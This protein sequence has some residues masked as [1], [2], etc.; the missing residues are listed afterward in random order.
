MPWASGTG[1]P[2]GASPSPVDR[3]H[4]RE[5]LRKTLLGLLAVYLLP[6]LLLTVYF[7]IQTL[8]SRE[9]SHR[10]QLKSVAEY[11][12]H[13]LDLFIRERAVNLA[14]MVDLP[15]AEPT[16]SRATLEQYLEDLRRD[17]ET[18]VD[19]GV[20]DA[21]GVQVGYAGPFPVLERRDYG[22]EP[23]FRQ[24]KQRPD[25]FVITDV[26]LG[27]RQR[28][29]FT[30]AVSRTIDERFFA[31]RAT[32]DP[33]AIYDFITRLEG[34]KE[35]HT[36]IVN[37]NGTYQFVTPD[38]GASQAE[39]A[40]V[41]PN[42]PPTD[43]IEVSPNGQEIT[44]GYSW[45]VE[46]DWALLTQRAG[47]G[48]N[49]WLLGGDLYLAIVALLVI[50]AILVASILRARKRVLIEE[51][52][53]ATRA[54]LEHAAKLASVG[55]L[56]SGIAHEINNP[57]AV[58]SEEAGL[59]KDLM[60]PEFAEEA[61]PE[62][63]RTHLDIIHEAVFRC[64][65]ITRKLLGFVRRTEF[66]LSRHRIEQL[67]DEVLDDFFVRSMELEDIEIRRTYQDD[68]PAVM[69]DGSQ[70]Q[71]V[72][73]NIINNAA[74][75]ITGSGRI[76]VEIT[77][78]QKELSVAIA[79]DGMG[80]TPAQMEKI[81]MPFYTTKEVGE[82]TGLG[83]SVSYGIIQSLGGRIEVESASGRGTTFT[84]ILPLR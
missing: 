81:F 50:F 80:M 75:A 43:V 5:R 42:D 52:R 4:H 32:L 26:Y 66:S 21:G 46:A 64:R 44:V 79:D 38:W 47:P 73:L 74:D 65:D 78:E 70:L 12:A 19:V 6:F 41:P 28:P 14:N 83:L 36:I 11:Q 77:A 9:R 18:F 20:F 29:H 54:Q 53:D 84:I 55:E 30:I 39:S 8:Q 51:E 27:F 24:L 59:I 35:L 7:H 31:L 33:D 58:I 57:L 62:E 37:R 34:A 67:M 1:Q 71:Q 25:E 2:T 23:W 69:T 60:D 3:H 56:A 16:P 63:F 17:S 82:G 76:A 22:A 10:W 40:V 68:L 45:L 61:D 13:M 49:V 72:F 15:L 48:P